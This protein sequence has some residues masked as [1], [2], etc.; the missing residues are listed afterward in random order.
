VCGGE[1]G[2]GARPMHT[3]WARSV[4]D[5]CQDAA[6]PFFFKQWGEWEPVSYVVNDPQNGDITGLLKVSVDGK[7]EI[8]I[9]EGKN[10][11]NMLRVGKNK[12]GRL[13]DGREHNEFPALA[14]QDEGR[15]TSRRPA[16]AKAVPA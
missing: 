1:S 9:G 7:R 16:Q 2:P 12:S 15:T 8:I 4:R 5:Q 13:L 6:V 3:A 11:I 14:R 10:A